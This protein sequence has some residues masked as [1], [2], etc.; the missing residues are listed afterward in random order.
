[1]F[2]LLI[3]AFVVVVFSRFSEIENLV[4]TLS[5]G[6]WTWVAAALFLQ[7]LYY[8]VYTGLYQAAFSVAAVQ[9]RFWDILPVVFAALFVNVSA[10]VA[11]VGGAALFIDDAVQ[12]GESGSRAAAA[13][14]LALATEIGTFILPLLVGLIS[15]SSWRE[16][17]FY[18]IIGAL[19]VLLTAVA[20]A[21][22]L[23]LGRWGQARL[24]Q[25]LTAVRRI[26]NWAVDKLN[27]PA[28]LSE[29]WA[30][31]NAQEFAGAADALFNHP[32]H[33]AYTASIGLLAHGVN[34]ACLY[35]LILAFYQPVGLRALF[36]G[37]AMA[38]TFRIVSITPQGAGVAEG[39]IALVYASLGA[40]DAQAVAIALTFRGISIW[41]PVVIGF[42]LL[43]QVR[44]FK[45]R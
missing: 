43:Q 45:D 39:V 15:L 2:W 33:L 38:V 30:E 20:L 26:V 12:R 5:H 18:E 42:F 28:L 14:I 32:K 37:Y 29:H 3:L 1:L 22:L 27:R 17:A 40:P 16:L 4:R 8:L 25:F 41:L 10:P 11:N 23:L 36:A 19:L 44:A 21:G 24:R 7:A 6:R 9:S 34:M 13:V 31:N 35:A